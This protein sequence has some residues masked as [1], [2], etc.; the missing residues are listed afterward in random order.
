MSDVVDAKDEFEARRSASIFARLMGLCADAE[1]DLLNNP[2]PHLA[3]AADEVCRLREAVDLAI[4]HLNGSDCIAW[5]PSTSEP[6]YVNAG[7][8]AMQRNS[9][10]LDALISARNR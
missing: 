3:R 2:G 1:R 4:A 9:K 8:E 10:A 5:L 6:V 7:A